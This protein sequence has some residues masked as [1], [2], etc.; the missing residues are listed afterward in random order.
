MNDR[1]PVLFDTDIGSDID[2][3]VALA[4]LLRQPRCELVGIT[5][6]SGAQQDRA[7]LADAVCRAAGRDDVPIHCGPEPSLHRGVTQPAAPQAEALV[8]WPH[9]TEFPPATA[10]EYLRRTIR[11]RPGEIVLLAVGPLTNIGL[12]FATDPEIPALLRGF[13]AMAGNFICGG[14]V[15]P[16]AEWNVKCDPE[17]AAIAFDRGPDGTMAVGLDVTTCCR[18]AAAEVR[19][20][21]AAAGGPLAAVLDFAEVWFRRAERL[22]FHDPLAAA[23]VFEPELCDWQT[24]RIQVDTTSSLVAGLTRFDTKD[25][26]ARHRVAVKVDS[27]GFFDHYFGIVGR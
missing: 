25:V 13:V 16:W 10:I 6:A 15:G 24:G 18:L 7:R 2:D 22:T 27:D 21:F 14:N 1:I 26:P 17:A 4:Y 3:A 23:V 20:K 9:R 8:D 12:L 5:C 19:E 11:E